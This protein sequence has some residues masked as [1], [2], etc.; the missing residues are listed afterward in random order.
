MIAASYSFTDFPVS[1]VNLYQWQATVTD[2]VNSL[3]RDTVRHT[4][5]SGEAQHETPP[6]GTLYCV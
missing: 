5:S 2:C 6:K 1:R 4:N 3:M